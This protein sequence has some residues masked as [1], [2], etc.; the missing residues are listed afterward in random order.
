MR[1]SP[2]EMVGAGGPYLPGNPLAQPEKD[3]TYVRAPENGPPLARSFIIWL[4]PPLP[5]PCVY[6]VPLGALWRAFSAS[7]SP[8]GSPGVADPQRFT[9]SA[10]FWETHCMILGDLRTILGDGLHG[11]GRPAA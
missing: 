10:R 11:S 5:Y 9:E 3:P 1:P 2:W 8:S 4:R 6:I 7:R